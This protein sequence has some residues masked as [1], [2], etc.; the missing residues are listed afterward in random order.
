VLLGGGRR[1]ALPEERPPA[2][3]EDARGE[4]A[5]LAG[6]AAPGQ[7]RVVDVRRPEAGVVDVVSSV[8]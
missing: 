2:E 7:R 4:L 8:A 5:L 6:P 3:V 1:A